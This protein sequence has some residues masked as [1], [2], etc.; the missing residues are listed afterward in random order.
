MPIICPLTT[1]S[2]PVGL[3]HLMMHQPFRCFNLSA[4]SSYA[5]LSL[6]QG[7][8][9]SHPRCNAH[10]L[11]AKP[12]QRGSILSSLIALALDTIWRGV[13]SDD[14]TDIVRRIPYLVNF[15]LFKWTSRAAIQY[16]HLMTQDATAYSA[17]MLSRML[18]DNLHADDT[19]EPIIIA[20]EYLSRTV[21]GMGFDSP[22]FTEVTRSR[23]LDTGLAPELTLNTFQRMNT[24]AFY[25]SQT[26]RVENQ[27]LLLDIHDPK[28]DFE[29]WEAWV[30]GPA[31]SLGALAQGN[32]SWSM[33]LNQV[34]RRCGICLDVLESSPWRLLTH[35]ALHLQKLQLQI[36][37]SSK[38]CQHRRCR[39]NGKVKTV[40]IVEES[41]SRTCER[42]SEEQ[43]FRR[44]GWMLACTNRERAI[45]VQ[46]QAAPNLE[47]KT[48]SNYSLKRMRPCIDPSSL[49]IL[50]H[51][52][53][54][55]NA[56]DNAGASISDG[57]SPHGDH[58]SLP[59][60]S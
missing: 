6:L 10:D 36:N 12:F 23:C 41:A 29:V 3:R 14:L 60:P 27:G 7:L 9:V 52:K 35:L 1:Q 37:W 47:I 4:L 45:I 32:G 18:F 56:G 15:A 39:L 16:Q 57:M 19:P 40:L 50:K 26:A 46:H 5:L 24:M 59:V 38:T 48:E 33:I 17:S 30:G 58:R 28:V 13:T 53:R 31:I 21:H 11:L 44:L 54:N 22:E 20:L 51:G 42:E 43:S 55:N 34:T 2:V 49:R 25:L 8:E